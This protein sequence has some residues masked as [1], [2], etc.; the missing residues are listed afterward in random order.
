MQS[1]QNEEGYRYWTQV[2]IVSWGTGCGLINTYGY[3]THIQRL[4][5]WVMKEM[6]R[7]I[8]I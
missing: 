4:M 3:Y 8:G 7:D 1:L 2:G 5:P 6:R